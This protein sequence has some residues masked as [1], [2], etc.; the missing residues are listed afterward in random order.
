MLL[1]AGQYRDKD[2]NVFPYSNINISVRRHLLGEIVGQSDA[3][4]LDDL[5]DILEA[6]QEMSGLQ[7]KVY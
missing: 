1:K 2:G 4:F 5:D 6:S 3:E 7:V